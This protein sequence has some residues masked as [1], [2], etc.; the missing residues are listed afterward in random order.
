MTEQRVPGPG[1][2]VES[3]HRARVEGWK[4]AIQDSLVTAVGR[5]PAMATRNDRYLAVAHAVRDRLVRRWMRTGEH[6]YRARVRSVCYLSAE[7]LLGPHLG[8]ALVALGVLDEVRQAVEEMGWGFDEVLAQEEEPGLGNGG[9]G[10]L[11]AC[12]MDSLATL[13]IPAIGYGIRYEFGI[14]DQE[15]RDGWQVEKTDKW[16]QYGNPWEVPRPEI[17]FDVKLGGRT[18]AFTDEA[19]RYRVRWVPAQVVKGVAYDTPIPGYRVGNVNLLRLFKAEAAESFDFAAFNVGDYYG[20]VEEKVGSETISKVL[21]PNDEPAAGKALRLSQ[22]HF[23]VSCSLQDMVRIHLQASPD[24][25]DLA[26][27]WAVQLNDT[28]PAIAVAELMRLL[29]DE[30]LLGWDAAWEI[31][32]KAFAYTNH[33]LLPEAL[34]KWPVELFGRTLP[35]HLEIVYEINRRF[36]DEVR[37][38]F[39][40][41]EGLA[42]RLSLVDEAGP[43]SIRMA[44]IAAVGSHHVNGV[45]A[46]HSE[47]LRRDVMRDFAAIWPEKFT[48]VTNGVTP[49]RFVALANPGLTRLVTEAIGDGWVRDLDELSRLEPLA[50]DA[51]FREA[52]RRVKGANRA[53]L[54]E[55]ARH[56]A[57]VSADPASLWDVQVKRI[58]EYK[59]QHLNLLHVL[60]LYR[61]LKRDP[62]LDVPPRTVL[63]AGKAAPGYATAKLIIKAI[64]SVAEVV[65]GD[66]AMKG[67]L[68]VVFWPDYNVRSSLPIF[69]GADLSEQI[70]TAGKEASGTGNMKLALNGALTIGTLDG[71]NVEIREAV[72]AGHFFLFGLTV[73]EVERT[74]R[75]GYRPGERYEADPELREAVDALVSGELTRGDRGLLR[76]LVH[77]LLTKDPF[78]V[79]ADYRAYVDAQGEVEE[80]WR[81]PER[82]TRDS[83]LNTARMGRFSSDRSIRDYAREIWRVVPAPVPVVEGE[84]RPA[85]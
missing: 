37:G 41:D 6:Y 38:R 19:G 82:W 51:G 62:G 69:A 44:H 75:D 40:G 53:A 63:F 70:S 45:A 23:F 59:R 9:L 55:A 64:H 77:G 39:P 74:W 68:A 4:R 81:D 52:W 65:N 73:E 79:L 34:E 30:H 71:A 20:A 72:G 42:A 76:P 46:L 54:A 21:Y 24:L 7:F 13:Q 35:R 50:E 28:H 8:N 1:D 43:R 67:R 18:E 57:G 5:F 25:T 36:L 27:R 85:L 61:R 84:E 58:H 31:T 11:A 78:L 83:I 2:E 29:V 47:L 14:F 15:I 17:A 10:R 16:L 56:R 80:A 32:R 22:Q 12:F 60:T 33:T 26:D 3:V 66:P 48:N 49:R